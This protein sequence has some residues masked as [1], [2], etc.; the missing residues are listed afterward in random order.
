M[1]DLI[2]QTLKYIIKDTP[3]GELRDAMEYALN[4]GG[5]RVRPLLLLKTL[6]S[7]GL[8]PKPYLQVASSIEMIHTYSLIHD[9][10]PAM[11]DDDLRRNQ[12]TLHIQ[13]NEAT[14]ILAGDALL[15][16]AFKLL[17]NQTFIDEKKRIK[18]V[19]IL[20]THSGSNGMVYGQSLDLLYENKVTPIEILQEI[21]I[22][23]TAKLIQAPLLMA[24]IIAGQKD[25]DSL[26]SLGEAL[27][28]VFQVQDDLLESLSDEKTMGKSL[29]DDT[30]EKSTYV[31]LLGTKETKK[32]VDN[33]FNTIEKT[34]EA[35]Y[36]KDKTPLSNL[37]DQVKN[38][39]N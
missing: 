26:A 29:S 23:K 6:E 20:S 25:L 2:N 13:F 3:K 10:L 35:I 28:L 14:A 27:G 17:S 18:L 8:D 24:G 5:K 21:H 34:L 19:E 37:I 33:L 16:D 11:D 9:D 32:I 7:Y 36:F 39:I 30:N 1:K 22:H 12:P 31:K 15:T 38:R 4:T